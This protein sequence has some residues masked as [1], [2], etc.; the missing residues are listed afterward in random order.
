LA[1][2]NKFG[3]LEQCVKSTASYWLTGNSALQHPVLL[4]THY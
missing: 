1:N 4:L 2:S 3:G